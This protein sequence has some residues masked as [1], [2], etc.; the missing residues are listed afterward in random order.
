MLE[1][2]I[3]LLGGVSGAWA[4]WE[5]FMR[6][7]KLEINLTVKYETIEQRVVEQWLDQRGLTWQPKGIDFEHTRKKK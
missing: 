7:E 3:F 5:V 6:R 2:M 1:I 4:S